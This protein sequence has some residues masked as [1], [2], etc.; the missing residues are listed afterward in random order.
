MVL[1]IFVDNL[2]RSKLSSEKHVQC[3]E[4][5]PVCKRCKRLNLRCVRGLKLLW[6]EDAAQRGINF[7]REEVYADLGDTSIVRIM[8]ITAQSSIFAYFLVSWLAR[9]L[10]RAR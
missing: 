5:W 8:A 1:S 3:T 4:D 9:T 6:R 2:F 10:L 7:G